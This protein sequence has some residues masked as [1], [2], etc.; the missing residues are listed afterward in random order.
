MNLSRQSEAVGLSNSLNPGNSQE[1]RTTWV[2]PPALA[3]PSALCQVHPVPVWT[4][5]PVPHP[6]A[7]PHLSRHFYPVSL[8]NLGKMRLFWLPQLGLSKPAS[9]RT[10]AVRQN[11]HN[12]YIFLVNK[13][14]VFLSSRAN[15]EPQSRL[16]GGTVEEDIILG[17]L[18]LGCPCA[19][20]G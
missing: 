2:L 15:R 3:S 8:N 13:H 4:V 6:P 7:P 5:P 12:I 9:L 17:V 11:S 1:T 16:Q 19:G 18:L 14:T 10:P 20:G